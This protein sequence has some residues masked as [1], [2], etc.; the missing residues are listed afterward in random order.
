MDPKILCI[1]VCIYVHLSQQNMIRL[2][3]EENIVRK[4][5]CLGILHNVLKGVWGFISIHIKSEY[6]N[7]W[8]QIGRTY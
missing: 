7:V 6:K 4:P 3:V 8:E 5:V 1:T 2:E